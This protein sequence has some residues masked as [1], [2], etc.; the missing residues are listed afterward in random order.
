MLVML[1]CYPLFADKIKKLSEKL[2]D[3]E[4]TTKALDG[5]SLEKI[6]RLSQLLGETPQ[7]EKSENQLNQEAELPHDNN[8]SSEDY[9]VLHPKLL[10]IVRRMIALDKVAYTGLDTRLKRLESAIWT[11][12]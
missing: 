4:M 11:I 12:R 3:G 5:Q 10:E 8:I 7:L 1:N 9:E 2:P 6:E